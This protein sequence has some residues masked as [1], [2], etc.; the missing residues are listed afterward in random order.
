MMQTTINLR[1]RVAS[2]LILFLSLL[3]GGLL[4][5]AVRAQD[6]SDPPP[7]SPPTASEPPRVHVLNPCTTNCITLT[8]PVAGTE[9]KSFRWYHNG[10]LIAGAVDA[11][12]EICPV[13]AADVGDYRVEA[14][15]ACGTNNVPAATVRFLQSLPPPVVTCPSNVV[16]STCSSNGVM[17]QFPAPTAVDASGQTLAVECSQASGDFFPVGTTVVSCVAVDA[18][19]NSGGC[20]FTV[21]VNLEGDLEPPVLLSITPTAI[22]TQGGTPVTVHGA[23]FLP[24]DEIW[25]G[26]LPLQDQV[27]LSAQEIWGRAPQLP[28]GAY[29]VWVIRCDQ[30]VARLVQA[31]QAQDTVQVRAVEPDSVWAS[32]GALVRVHGH[33]FSKATRV[34]IGFPSEDGESN[35]MHI[36]FV[37]EDGSSLLG[38]VPPLPQGQLYGP[39]AVIVE[40]P[41]GRS[42]LEAGLRYVPNPVPREPQ[43]MALS[44]LQQASTKKPV[45]SVVNGLVRS[46]NLRL[47][48]AGGNAEERARNFLQEH[49]DL[50][51]QE[52]PGHNLTLKRFT[53]GETEHVLLQQTHAGLPVAGAELLVSLMGDE[54]YSTVGAL[55]PAVQLALL[56]TTPKLTADE[57][58]ALARRALN[59]PAEFM[60]AEPSLEIFDLSLWRNVPIQPH[61]A[62]RLQLGGDDPVEVFVDAHTGELLLTLS[63][64]QEH[65]YDMAMRDAQGMTSTNCFSTVNLPLVGTDNTFFNTAYNGNMDAVAAFQ[66]AEDAFDFFHDN[67][68]FHSYDGNSSQMRIFINSGVANASWSPTCKIMQFRNGWVDYEVMVHE[69]THGIIGSGSNLKY[70]FESGA[71]NESYADVMATVADREAGDLNWLLAEDRTSGGG[72][73]RSLSD[74]TAFGHPDRY[75]LY[76]TGVPDSNGDYP[77]NGGVHSNSGIGNKAAYLLAQGGSFNG[78]YVSGVGLTKMRDLKFEALRNLPSNAQFIDARNFEV[79]TAEAW[80]QNSS[81]NFTDTTVCAVR[82]AWAA[83]EVGAPDLNCDGNEDWFDADN[84]GVPDWS[85][86][87]PLNPNPSQADYDGDGVGDACDNCVLTANSDQTD[88]D[89]DGMGDV[90][91]TD[92]DNDGCLDGNDQHPTDNMVQVG[93]YIGACCSGALFGFEGDDSDG[94]GQLNCEDLDD[95][96]DGTPDSQDGCPTGGIGP[97][98]C[99][100]FEDCPCPEKWWW[101][102]CHV[103]GCNE[104]FTKFTWLINPDPTREVIFDRVQVQN[105]KLYVFP[106]AGNTPMQGVRALMESAIAGLGA[107]FDGGG[108]GGATGANLWRMEIWSKAQGDTPA[109]L[110]G[111]VAEFDPLTLYLGQMELGRLLEVTPP[112]GDLPMTMGATWYVGADPEGAA[113]DSDGDGMPDGWETSYGLNPY[114]P[115]DALADKDNDGLNSLGEFEA[116]THPCDDGSYFGILDVVHE[117]DRVVMR[118]NTTLDL[119]YQLERASGLAPLEWKPV[120]D[121]AT[122]TGGLVE[123]EDTKPLEGQA[124]YRVRLMTP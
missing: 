99:T 113:N 73:I 46:V 117:S 59:R 26:G 48:V 51:Q 42:V 88:T 4:E 41:S 18:C 108:G 17:V 14:S 114:D 101:F 53:P 8:A 45:L 7:C 68:G 29:D 34:R 87:C 106:S 62:Y 67:F 44:R 39:R 104:L 78:L 89:D 109:Q 85:D 76:A 107:G 50:F 32:G 77:D 47:R 57:A 111:V 65:N 24:D 63:L 12:Y 23:H 31:V 52:D 40:G 13:T 83:V 80:A 74:P 103:V 3:L 116:H 22:S 61:L 75:S 98:G 15:N 55:L 115:A 96:N 1:H 54:V 27:G 37:E 97:L 84:D 20:T 86:N 92:D 90:C 38:T 2:A 10:S 81:H 16:V 60:P 43:A 36:L 66:Q 93:Q 94:D 102:L 21:T 121:P 123:V 112:K 122:G 95:D 79:A 5:N 100:V 69:L 35:L 6:P 70:A 91:D 28:P 120:G 71:L 30:I 49:R 19:G 105:N 119:G 56:E 11:D 64:N 110:L 82:R 25:I 124:F 118:I 33:N 72:A 9:P 58:Q